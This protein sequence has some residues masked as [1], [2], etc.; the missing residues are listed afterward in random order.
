MMIC[1]MRHL[2]MLSGGLIWLT[3]AGGCAGVDLKIDSPDAALPEGESSAGYLDRMA[4]QQTVSENDALR[5][6]LLLSDGKD[7]SETFAQRVRTLVERQVAGRSWS[8]RSDRPITR[9][10]LAYMVYQSCKMSGGVILALTGPSP[11]YCLRELQY[12]GFVTQESPVY[13]QV[14]GMEFVAILTR[15]D[16][17]LETGQVPLI[18]STN[19]GR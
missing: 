18:L 16:T 17:Y 6:I 1:R 10:K 3:V 19:Q 11:R 13:G 4:S 7:A 8:F 12:Q 9:G 15:A 5:G 2:V 14:T